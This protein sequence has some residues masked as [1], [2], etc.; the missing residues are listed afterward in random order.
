[1]CFEAVL[2]KV[3]PFLGKRKITMIFTF[4]GLIFEN[5]IECSAYSD[6]IGDSHGDLSFK[7]HFE[8]NVGAGVFW[9]NLITDLVNYYYLISSY[10]TA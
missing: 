4:F 5:A 7:S 6:R 10:F 2:G 9:H 3:D 1:M 8:Y